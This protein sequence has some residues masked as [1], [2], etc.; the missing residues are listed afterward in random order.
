MN[1]EEL[2]EM[3][4]LDL[5][6]YLK[7]ELRADILVELT[8]EDDDIDI[9]I[10]ALEEEVLSNFNNSYLLAKQMYFLMTNAGFSIA[11]K[12]PLGVEDDEDDENQK[13]NL[14]LHVESMNSLNQLQGIFEEERF[15]KRYVYN[16]ILPDGSEIN[17]LFIVT[18]SSNSYHY[19]YINLRENV[20]NDGLGGIRLID[21]YI[22]LLMKKVENGSDNLLG[23]DYVLGKRKKGKS[24]GK[25]NG[26]GKSKGKRKGKGKSKGKRN[27]KGKSKGKY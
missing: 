5:E 27:G 2:D 3:N 22:K 26:K 20:E 13:F 8:E 23:A 16:G 7:S 24:K 1:Q 15:N 21:N 4:Q 9:D 18:L 25:R 11:F 10:V 6:E 17:S 12:E 19:I 14:Y